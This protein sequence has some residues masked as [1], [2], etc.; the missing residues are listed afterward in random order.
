MSIPS[1]LNVGQVVLLYKI[2]LY[3]CTRILVQ[4]KCDIIS[5]FGICQQQLELRI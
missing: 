2:L 3:F 4:N 5:A 1:K